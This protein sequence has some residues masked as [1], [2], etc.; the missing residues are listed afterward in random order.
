[1]SES[2]IQVYKVVRESLTEKMLKQKRDGCEG[3]SNVGPWGK[4]FPVR[5]HSKYRGPVAGAAWIFQEITMKA[6]SE[7]G[8]DA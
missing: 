8:K 7:W 2:V 1:M 6:N 3:I 4:N 5:R